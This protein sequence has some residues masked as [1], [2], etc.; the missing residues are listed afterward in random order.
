[1]LARR[2]AGQQIHAAH[3][4][5]Q[6]GG[7][8]WHGGQEAGSGAF[9]HRR[10]GTLGAG[11]DPLPEKEGGPVLQGRGQLRAGGGD[12]HDPGVAHDIALAARPH[13]GELGGEAAE[14]PVGNEGPRRAHVP[15]A[16]GLPQ[17]LGHLQRAPGDALLGQARVLPAQTLEPLEPRNRLDARG[18]LGTLAVG[19]RAGPGAQGPGPGA[20]HPAGQEPE[21]QVGREQPDEEQDLPAADGAV[22]QAQG[23]A[24][25]D[26]GMAVDAGGK[27]VAGAE[28]VPAGPPGMEAAA[29]AGA[30]VQQGRHQ[31]AEGQDARGG[32]GVGVRDGRGIGDLPDPPGRVHGRPVSGNGTDGVLR[33]RWFPLRYRDARP[34]SADL[35]APRPPAAVPGRRAL[36]PCAA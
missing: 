23:T 28:A 18:R 11:F 6:Q 13:H 25:A 30:G 5:V 3:G 15:G 32:G 17:D 34:D 22:A 21:Q 20:E 31:E 9:P 1:M 24:L 27:A 10:R 19:I 14:H 26:P 33:A 7:R 8:G 36:S 4:H 2:T 29:A 16:P 12:G 35:R